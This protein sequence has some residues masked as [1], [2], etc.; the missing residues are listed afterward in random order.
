MVV[1]NTANSY[2][3]TNKA[4]KIM[5]NGSNITICQVHWKNICLNQQV[6]FF[7]IKTF[8]ERYLR[9]L[10]ITDNCYSYSMSNSKQLHMLGSRSALS[11]LIHNHGNQ[12]QMRDENTDAA[13]GSR[14]VRVSATELWAEFTAISSTAKTNVFA[15][16]RRRNW[17]ISTLFSAIHWR[18]Y[19][20]PS[21]TLANVTLRT[22]AVLV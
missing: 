16:Y 21:R 9:S 1:Q 4:R 13:V 6:P 20:I 3:L 11:C 8:T 17:S 14:T 19:R 22:R 12:A 5:K 2:V 18:I 15:P 7:N 10:Q